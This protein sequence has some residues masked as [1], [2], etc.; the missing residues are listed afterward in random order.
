MGGLGKGGVDHT[1]QQGE[2]TSLNSLTRSRVD[3]RCEKSRE[4]Q[5]TVRWGRPTHRSKPCSA[6]PS[7]TS[8]ARL[9]I[10]SSTSVIPITMTTVH[11]NTLLRILRI[12]SNLT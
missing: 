5:T 2:E 6:W 11:P 1:S 10:L 7:L 3:S 4:A 9:I 8:L 12:I